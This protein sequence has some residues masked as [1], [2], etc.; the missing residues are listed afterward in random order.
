MT[1]AGTVDE[2]DTDKQTSIKTSIATEAGVDV[3]NV[4]LEITAASVNIVAYVMVPVT[5]ALATVE[6]ALQTSFATAA[7][8][9]TL[10][11]SS[12]LAVTV[13]SEPQVAQASP[14]SSPSKKEN[15]GIIA[16][17]TVGGTLLIVIVLAICYYSYRQSAPKGTSQTPSGGV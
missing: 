7:E 17:A 1:A 14:P 8:A 10:L 5:M 15:A 3:E 13:E 6:N 11:S 12:L 4:I 2:Y 9:S 16:G